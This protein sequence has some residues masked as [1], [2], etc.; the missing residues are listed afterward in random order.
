M[1]V[2][3]LVGTANGWSER[4]QYIDPLVVESMCTIAEQQRLDGT[5]LGVFRPGEVLDLVVEKDEEEWGDGKKAVIA[6]PSL[7]APHKTA[8]TKIPY[9]FKYRYR[10]LT[11]GC[12]THEQSVI[13]WEISQAF[14][15]WTQYPERER[16]S[17]IR[18]KWLGDLCGGERD[19]HFF[20]GN[21]HLFPNSFV[22]LG[23]FYPPKV[24]DS[25]PE[26]LPLTLA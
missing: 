2:G 17:K 22:V 18:D 7:F 3:R 14:L 26:Q 19:T 21:Q 4:K 8:L 25:S 15:G 12:P 20:V 6:Q 23:V 16:L 13:D 9:R 5:S 24:V 10:C 11:H 1:T